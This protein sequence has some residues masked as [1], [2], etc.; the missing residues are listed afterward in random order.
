MPEAAP[1]EGIGV[2]EDP[3]LVVEPL[4]ELLPDGMLEPLG[5]MVDGLVDGEVDG[6]VEGVD[7]GAGVVVSLTFLPQAPS[8]SKPESARIVTAGL[9]WTKF[10]VIPFLIC[11]S[12]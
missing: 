2:L 4:L 1:V 8:A 10:M 6:L 3:G 9:R 12:R 7:I 11:E 5:G